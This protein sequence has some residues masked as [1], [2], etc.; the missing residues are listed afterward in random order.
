MKPSRALLV[1][2]HFPLFSWVKPF[3]QGWY[4]KEKLEPCHSQGLK[5]YRVKWTCSLSYNLGVFLS[6][7]QATWG[8]N[9]I[10]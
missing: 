8:G 5:G 10:P 4:C 6:E 2:D 9:R 1:F 3:I 7:C